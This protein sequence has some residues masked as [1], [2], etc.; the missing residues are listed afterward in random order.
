MAKLQQWMHV[1]QEA[2]YN[3]HQLSQGESSTALASAKKNVRYI[4][5]DPTQKEASVS[6]S[7][8]SK[9]KSITLLNDG[10]PVSF[11]WS[12]KK[13]VISMPET[14]RLGKE[15]SVLKITL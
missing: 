7:G 10:K 5:L 9:P 8:I 3:T 4:Y 13:A 1:N 6:I 11:D 2:I 15:W 14:P 12:K